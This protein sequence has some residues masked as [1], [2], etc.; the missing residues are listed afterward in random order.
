MKWIRNS[1]R[2]KLLVITGAATLVLLAAASLG[3]WHSWQGLAAI[4]GALAGHPELGD[5]VA[6][7]VGSAHTGMLV[8]LGLMGLAV[9]AGFAGFLYAV[10]RGLTAPAGELVSSLDRIAAGDFSTA[11]PTLGQDEF[12]RLARSIH[13]IQGELGA[14]IGR[15]AESSDQ[16]AEAAARMQGVAEETNHHLMNQ[17]S[18]TEQVASAMN[19]MSATAQEAARHAADAATA[20][21]QADKEAT[22]GAQIA[23]NAIARMDSL[24]SK[25]NKAAEVMAALQS[26]SNN[27][28]KVLEVITNIAEQTNLLALNAAIEAARA[29]EQGRGF[30]VVAEEVRALAIRTQQST[31]E[32]ETIIGQLQALAGDAAGAM[33]DASSEVKAGE[34]QVEQTAMS[35][36][37]IAGAVKT[38]DDMNSQIA[39]AAEEQSAVSEDINRNIATI[40][41]IAEQTSAGA[42]QTAS[43]S[44]GLANLA[45]ELSELVARF[46]LAR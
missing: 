42:Q 4:Q 44:N 16:I 39:T 10:T 35:L 31:Q 40:K 24:L 33:E 30:A 29:G 12:G 7:A 20:A 18:E 11:V 1:I 5:T 2:S 27:V 23:T 25:V 26:E 19:E 13:S 28:S 36:G 45:G 37:E 17:Q 32:I 14:V 43:A 6:R 21:H 46:K 9:A 38:I 41:E 15:V 8:S 3:F 22:S 34:E